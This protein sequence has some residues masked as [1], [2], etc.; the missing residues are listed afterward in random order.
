MSSTPEKPSYA[1]LRVAYTH[2]T[3]TEADLAANPLEQ[4]ERWFTEAAALPEPNAMSLATVD[5][6]GRPGIRHVLLKQADDRGFVF[7]TNY[8]SA[9]GQDIAANPNVAIV[10]PWFAMFRQVIVRGRAEKVSRE[11]SLEYFNQRP[12]GSR[13]GAAVSNQSQVLQSRDE[14]DAR[15]KAL[16]EKYPN[17]V[18]LPDQWGGYVVIPQSIEFW[19]GR[20]SR[21]HDRLRY[22]FVGEGAV[23]LS[24]AKQWKVERLSP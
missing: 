11:E 16:E 23:S 22:V 21:L 20:E 15:W 8:E 13:I 12:H 24:D 14:L 19:A 6:A 18:P 7:Y 1:Q 2:Q 10:F 4:F 9:K 5:A 3:L 17:E